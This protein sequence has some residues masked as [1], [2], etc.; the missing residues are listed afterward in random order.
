[1]PTHDKHYQ[2][3]CMGCCEV[4]QTGTAKN[5]LRKLQLE[6]H[7]AIHLRDTSS[8]DPTPDVCHATV[9]NLAL[10][11][12]SN[13]V[14]WSRILILSPLHSLQ[15]CSA[16][17]GQILSHNPANYGPHMKNFRKMHP[18]QTLVMSLLLLARFL[19]RICLLF[20]H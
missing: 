5:P 15:P 10:S 19:L 12:V 1:M 7:K 16:T 6:R 13:R 18:V 20:L 2:C 17:M 14:I 9:A 4:D 3:Y 11:A 8:L